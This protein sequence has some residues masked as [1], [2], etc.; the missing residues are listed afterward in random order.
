MHAPDIFAPWFP[1]PETF[2]T[3]FTITKAI[4]GL[5]LNDEELETFHLLTGRT[6][7]PKTAAKEVWI[8]AGRRAAKSRQMAMNAVWKAT[9]CYYPDLAPG[10]R[11]VAS[12]VATDKK[13]ARLVFRYVEALVN[14]VPALKKM[15]IG[16]T[17]ESFE[18][19][20]GA[21]IEVQAASFRSVRG[22]SYVFFGVDEAAFLRDEESANP[23]SELYVAALP[24]LATIKSSLFWGS[25]SPWGKRGLVF[26]KYSQHWGKNT[27]PLVF[28][29]PTKLFNPTIEDSFIQEMKDRDPAA[30]E[31]EWFGE[32]RSDLASFIA[33]ETVMACVDKNVTVRAPRGDTRYV[34]FVDMSGGMR[35]SATA[36]IAHR[37][38]ER[39]IVDCVLEYKAPFSPAEVIGEMCD[40]IKRYRVGTVV[41][42]RYAAEFPRDHFR[43]HGISLRPA[44][45]NRSQLYLTL[46]PGLLSQSV[47]LVNNERLISQLCGLERRTGLAGRTIIDHRPGSNDDVSNSVAGVVAELIA[48]APP[49]EMVVGTYG[50]GRPNG[51]PL[52][53]RYSIG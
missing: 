8:I 10:E 9:S 18:F 39:V 20:N 23:D 13:Q 48:T 30:A 33:L 27:G 38:G 36:A 45:Q 49:P 32:F 50:F 3:W 44:E 22:R 29:G 31:S 16:E 21:S 5:P 7:A 51:N 25:S 43:R 52:V 11:A 17:Q 28:K 2:R 34:C 37:E 12:I 35:D 26:D 15:K 6:E 14:G 19:D 42:D 1:N 24:G 47:S 40:V 46:L 41:S 53:G 4:E